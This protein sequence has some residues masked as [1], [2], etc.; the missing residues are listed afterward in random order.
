MAGCR[1]GTTSAKARWQML[2]EALVSSK[3]SLSQQQS[4]SP[5]SVRRFS[6]FD[7][8]DVHEEPTSCRQHDTDENAD[9]FRWLNY[10]YSS[11][12]AQLLAVNVAILTE[13]APR[14]QELVG[15]NNTGNVCMWPSEEVMA[16]FCLENLDQFTGTAVCELGAGM[17]GLAGIFLASSHKPRQVVIT[18]GNTKSVENLKRTVAENV[19]KF[20]TTSVS[21]EELLWDPDTLASSASG[22]YDH[23]FCAD[24]LFFEDLHVSLAQVICKLLRPDGTCHIFAPRRGQSM[25]LFC[26]RAE[27][28]FSIELIENYSELVWRNHE[29][30]CHKL[31]PNRLYDPDIHYPVYLKL[32]MKR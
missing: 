8:F 2:R 9:S 7:L 26:S 4:Q 27:T 14:L 24:C 3:R 19:S 12:E 18:D 20:G 29:E 31:Q 23:I 16:F 21:A 1:E 25:Q 17:V 22:S 6:S 11:A 15:F 30:N 13:K 10:S 32:K 28:W 5:F